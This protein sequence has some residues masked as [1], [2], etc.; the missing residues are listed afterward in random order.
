MNAL[1]Q[2]LSSEE[3]RDL[4]RLLAAHAV[5]LRV[6]LT[7]GLLCHDPEGWLTPAYRDALRPHTRELVD[8]LVNSMAPI[9]VPLEIDAPRCSGCR[10]LE[11]VDVP[12]HGGESARR[13]CARCHHTAG[14]PLWYGVADPGFPLL[15]QRAEQQPTRTRAA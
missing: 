13:D 4:L 1:P 6:S 3:A 12:I 15:T 5:E 9:D 14:F 2:T 7:G 8:E 11:F 10:S